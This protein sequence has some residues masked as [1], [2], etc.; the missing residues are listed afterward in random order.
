MVCYIWGITKPKWVSVQKDF[1]RESLTVYLRN[2]TVKLTRSC[3]FLRLL[4]V[5]RAEWQRRE[6]KTEIEIWIRKGQMSILPITI[7]HQFEEECKFLMCHK[8]LLEQ[9][10]L[11]FWTSSLLPRNRKV[12]SLTTKSLSPSSSSSPNDA[13]IGQRSS[14][15][16]QRSFGPAAALS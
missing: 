12:L 8:Y 13:S 4:V 10:F 3:Y 14:I 16:F 7:W 11:C 9:D 1:S 15:H 5:V 2:D 6:K